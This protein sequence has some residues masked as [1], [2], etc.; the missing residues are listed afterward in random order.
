MTNKEMTE[1]FSIML[2][3]WPN[4]ETFRG[5]IAKLGPTIRLWATCTADIDF[6]TGQQAMIRLVE[7]SKFPPS[8]AEFKEQAKVVEDR[9]KMASGRFLDRM[10]LHRDL[11]KSALDYYARLSTSDFDRAVIDRLGGTENLTIGDRWNIEGIEEACRAV[12]R[13]RPAV[14]GG[15]PLALPG[16]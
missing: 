1:L 10:R 3:A 4:A 9:I 7:T 11:G 14:V 12:I 6:W 13:S 16:K 5:G 8:I 2:L 15:R